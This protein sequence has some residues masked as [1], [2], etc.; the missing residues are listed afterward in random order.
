M[1][2]RPAIDL[3]L[4]FRARPFPLQGVATGAHGPRR[5]TPRATLLATLK[6]QLPFMAP[7]VKLFGIPMQDGK[8]N[9]LCLA[10]R[11]HSAQPQ[12]RKI[13]MDP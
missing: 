10:L 3:A 7:F 11:F 13:V 1:H 6:A 9:R 8:P 2:R 4:P 12:R 5:M